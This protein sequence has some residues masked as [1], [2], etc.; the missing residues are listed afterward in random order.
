MDENEKQ[1][2]DLVVRLLRED[3]EIQRAVLGVVMRSPNVVR[4]G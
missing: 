3:R 4:R 2:A 1:L